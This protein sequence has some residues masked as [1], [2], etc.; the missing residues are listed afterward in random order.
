MGFGIKRGL[1]RL[2]ENGT[3]RIKP[4]KVLDLEGFVSTEDRWNKQDLVIVRR[5]K[6]IPLHGDPQLVRHGGKFSADIR[7]LKR[8]EKLIYIATREDLYDLD[9]DRKSFGRTF[10]AYDNMAYVKGIERHEASMDHMLCESY[11]ALTLCLLAF[12]NQIVREKTPICKKDHFLRE[13]M[14][15]FGVF[16]EKHFND[17]IYKIGENLPCSPGKRM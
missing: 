13:A 1:E 8:I 10:F 17:S 16:Q 9:L 12:F 2:Q 6:Y 7:C 11:W 5:R 4:K 15:F 3:L 14:N